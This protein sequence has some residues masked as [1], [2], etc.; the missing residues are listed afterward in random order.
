MYICIYVYMYIYVYICI[1]VYIYIHIHDITQTNQV[2][3][4]DTRW[5]CP[6]G[7]S[8]LDLTR[9]SDKVA[10]ATPPNARNA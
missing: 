5:I 4:Q 2:K 6:D 7:P 10:G 3:Y 9:A 1:Y 8:Q